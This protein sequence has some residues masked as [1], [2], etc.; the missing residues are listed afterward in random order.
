LILSRGET[1]YGKPE[2]GETARPFN[3]ASSRMVSK[4]GNHFPLSA[5]ERAGVRAGDKTNLRPVSVAVTN[6]WGGREIMV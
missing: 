6:G 4:R 2:L 3:L 5:E 1:N